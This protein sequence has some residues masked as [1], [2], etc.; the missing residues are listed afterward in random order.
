MNKD[1]GERISWEE[2]E[3]FFI[4]SGFVEL[5]SSSSGRQGALTS[6]QAFKVAKSVCKCGTSTPSVRASLS[7]TGPGKGQFSKAIRTL[8]SSTNGY[9]AS[10]I[11]ASGFSVVTVVPCEECCAGN[12]T[13][14]TY[15]IEQFGAD[16]EY[17]DIMRT[18]GGQGTINRLVPGE[19]YK[20]RVYGL[21]ED[22]S[23]GPRSEEILLH[24]PYETP[25]AP[26]VAL[27]S[28][29]CSDGPARALIGPRSIVLRWKERQPIKLA[30]PREKS[31]VKKM[32]MEWSGQLSEGPT[33]TTAELEKAFKH[34]DV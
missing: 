13:K 25:A 14:T 26:Y 30:N 32:L 27:A 18:T 11:Y 28:A 20:F 1:S 8:R 34:F 2:L 12:V 6:R 7:M 19:T 33:V 21:N 29:C 10:N 17:H 31:F 22:G 3:R 24:M 5:V 9:N 4:A 23:A 16:G 15:T